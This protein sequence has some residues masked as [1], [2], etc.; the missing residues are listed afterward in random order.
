[1]KEWVKDR[2]VHPCNWDLVA[3]GG[4]AR[5]SALPLTDVVNGG[6]RLLVCSTLAVLV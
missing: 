5:G 3:E 6:A 4:G 2:A 1:M